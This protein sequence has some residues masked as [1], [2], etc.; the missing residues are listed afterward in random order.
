MDGYLVTQDLSRLIPN[1]NLE[2][3][4]FKGTREHMSK[5]I[6]N[7]QA[8]QQR[9]MSCR[10]KVGGFPYLAETLR[11]AGVTRNLWFLPACQS[12]YL[13]EHGPVVTQG[14]PLVTGT[15]DVPPFD[16]EALIAALRIDQVGNSAF[17]E[18]LAAS[19]RAG[20]V[21]YDVD[22][23]ARKV[24]YYG[25]RNEEYVEDYPAVNVE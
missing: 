7:L 21:R 6:E 4:K 15:V 19:W 25:S 8:A 17:P 20:V 3:P 23:M 24:A 18:F 11:Q 14:A 1:V 10:P 22:F 9:A 13:T 5:A 2:T 16:R 12:L